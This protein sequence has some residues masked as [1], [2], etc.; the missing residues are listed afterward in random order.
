MSLSKT[1]KISLVQLVWLGFNITLGIGYVV[2][3]KD[4]V[5]G[6]SGVGY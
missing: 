6:P 1:K 3:F 5:S 2:T 4:I